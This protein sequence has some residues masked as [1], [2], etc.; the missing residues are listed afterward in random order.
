MLRQNIVKYFIESIFG[1]VFKKK[2]HIPEFENTKS[3]S[4][5]QS[6]RAHTGQFRIKEKY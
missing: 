1:V 6:G 2:K 5:K 3:Q 4:P